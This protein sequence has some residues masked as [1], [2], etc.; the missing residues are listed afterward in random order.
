MTL[1]ARCRFHDWTSVDP[2]ASL[3]LER[4]NI[5]R[6]LKALPMRELAGI[7]KDLREEQSA[8]ILKSL[9]EM[10]GIK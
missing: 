9:R 2:S 8:I 10:Y 3:L 1:K 6:E 5:L 4:L 7:I